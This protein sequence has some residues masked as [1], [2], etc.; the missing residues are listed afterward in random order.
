MASV[1]VWIEE[2]VQGSL[3]RG[4]CADDPERDTADVLQFR[5]LHLTDNVQRHRP[6]RTYCADPF[7]G[8]RYVCDRAAGYQAPT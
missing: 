5:G 4:P 6:H 8:A 3:S 2:D 7:L 1:V